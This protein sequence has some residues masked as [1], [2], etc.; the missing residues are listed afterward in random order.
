MLF[1]LEVGA[2][3]QIRFHDDFVHDLACGATLETFNAGDVALGPEAVSKVRESAWAIDV[4][5][6]ICDHQPAGQADNQRN[7]KE[8]QSSHCGASSG[9]EC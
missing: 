7:K 1:V 3:V 5:I 2:V 9:S 4:W 8:D 6:L